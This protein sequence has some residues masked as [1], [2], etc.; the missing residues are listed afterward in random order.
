[1]T[2]IISIFDIENKKEEKCLN[3]CKQLKNR[4]FLLLKI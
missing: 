3:N 4:K 1:M 2:I